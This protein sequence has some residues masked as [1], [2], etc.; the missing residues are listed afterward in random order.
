MTDR[1]GPVILEAI[2]GLRDTG[3]EVE[4][5][6]VSTFIGGDRNRVFREL[7]RIFATAARTGEHVV[8]T[9]LLSHG[10]P[11]ETYC[12][13][14][15]EVRM[16]GPT[17]ASPGKSGVD[18]S[19]QWSLYPLGSE[20]Y[21][22]VIYARQSFSGAE[23][24]STLSPALAS[25]KGGGI[26][27]LDLGL[28]A[29]ALAAALA[30]VFVLVSWARAADPTEGR[31]RLW[32]AAAAITGLAF[33]MLFLASGLLGG[34]PDINFAPA[35][36]RTDNAVKATVAKAIG[37]GDFV[38]IGVGVY[39]AIVGFAAAAIGAI[40]ARPARDER[41][42][43]TQDYVLL[44]ILA[45]VFG[46][47]YW[48]WL[49]PYLGIETIL[50]GVRSEFGQELLFGLWFVSG[51]L[52]GYIIR[53]PGA[54]FLSETLAAF[55]EILL[56]APAGPILIVTGFMQAL[57]AEITFAATGY[58][59]WGWGTMIVAGVAAALVALPWNWLRLGYFALDPALLLG[60]LA[61]RVIGGGFAGAV[62]KIL[63]DLVA[64]TGSLNYFALG[65]ERVREV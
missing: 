54:A 5:D 21:M 42:W 35:A 16:P 33:G 48:A 23:L 9:V 37:A 34:T 49:G 57:G 28:W 6:D 11:G 7:E 14:T 63:G 26:K 18:V 58:R 4:T 39:L 50:A 55:A 45:V 47:I 60:L 13:A 52:G 1:Y 12:E 64:A 56:G 22:Q 10:C 3:L 36:I 44:A 20:G 40:L 46:A 53:R 59:R 30:A 25:V 19:A 51:L 41:V 24:A 65:R 29:V 27:G 61:V 8:M 15:G 43:R 62:A 17:K 38:G 31:Y 2:E 32:A